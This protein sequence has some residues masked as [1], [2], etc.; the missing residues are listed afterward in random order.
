MDNAGFQVFLTVVIVL[1][2]AVVLRMAWH[3]AYKAGQAEALN[4]QAHFELADG[5]YGKLSQPTNIICKPR[6]Q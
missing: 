6:E 2:A 4:G 3:G 5:Y 1:V